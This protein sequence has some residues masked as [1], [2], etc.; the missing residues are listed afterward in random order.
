MQ[1]SLEA[2]G[3]LAAAEREAKAQIALANASAEAIRMI[4]ENIQDKE[5]PAMFLTW[6]QIH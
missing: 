3:K 4:S 5:L 6:R 2:D 1:P